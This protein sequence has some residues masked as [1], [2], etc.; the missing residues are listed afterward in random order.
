MQGLD[1]E[2]T[3]AERTLQEIDRM[4]RSVDAVSVNLSAGVIRDSRDDDV[5]FNENSTYAKLT[6]SYRLGAINPN[7]S[8][9]E[10]IAEDARVEALRETGHGSL[11]YTREMASAMTRVR[12]GLLVQRERL[13]SAIVEARSNAQK[14]SEGYEIAIYQSKYR[15]QVDVIKLTSELRGLEGT[16]V[17]IDKVERKLR[18]R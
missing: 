16:L 17:D 9:Y 6:V 4:R 12:E 15:A 7:R 3:D 1:Q 11:W 13:K 18:F 14:F 2:L 8:A 5:L 10:R